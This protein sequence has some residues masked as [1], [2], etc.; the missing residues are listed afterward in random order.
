MDPDSANADKYFSILTQTLNPVPFL[1]STIS[2]SLLLI[3]CHSTP[4]EKI[5]KLIAEK[6]DSSKSKPAVTATVT[7]AAK[8]KKKIYLTFDDGPNKG[9]N[10]VMNILKDEN[11]PATLFIIGEQVFGSRA[12]ALTWDSLLTCS[13]I[14]LANH[15]YS[16]A[17]NSFAKFYTTPGA[18]VKDFEKC[19][20][21]LQLNNSLART[22]GRN[23][24]R[25]NNLS[26]TDLEKTRS[27]A[28]SV[29]QAGFNLIG[30]D[31][32]WHYDPPNL[33][34]RENA[35]LVL[36]QIDSMLANNKTRNA[37][38]IVVLAHDQTFADSK[39]STSLR[40]LIQQL[41]KRDDYEL[42]R[43]SNYPGVN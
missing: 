28:D 17:H 9:T 24:W 7:P 27:A 35:D 4:D 33:L 22:P 11:V 25:L 39:D 14:E 1:T 20:D 43:V 12:Q 6:K 36:Q 10:N 38:H 23:V 21:T 19:K 41:K 32:E 37:G 16:H 5:V 40:Y 13:N 15:S 3:S 31:L 30:W 34:L 18:V 8:Q 26:V 42:M 2:C 29:Q